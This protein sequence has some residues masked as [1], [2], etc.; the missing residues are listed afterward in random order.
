MN[1]GSYFFYGLSSYYISLPEFECKNTTASYVCSWGER[2]GKCEKNENL[3][4]ISGQND[5]NFDFENSF[6]HQ[7]GLECKSP[8]QIGWIGSCCFLGWA[9]GCFLM[10][11]YADNNGRKRP[12]LLSVLLQAIV[13]PF[14]LITKS[15]NV[16]Y[17]LCFIFGFCIAGRYTIGFVL[18]FEHMPKSHRMQVGLFYNFTDS[19]VVAIITLYFYAI[20]NNYR[21]LNIFWIVVSLVG[22]VLLCIFLV[23][24]PRYCFESMKYKQAEKKLMYIAKFNG[25]LN[26]LK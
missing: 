19:L 23:E 15:I 3:E 18:L 25:R 14:F 8:T 11:P 1:S 24:S 6:A 16:T 20:N 12:F 2:I 22:F 4:L 9:I 21:Y 17:F 13:W 26:E 10:A 5:L 7:I